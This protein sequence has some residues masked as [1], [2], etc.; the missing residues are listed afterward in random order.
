MLIYQQA[1]SLT[2]SAQHAV[3]L[4]MLPTTSKGN[5]PTEAAY[6]CEAAM[7]L[8]CPSPGHQTCCRPSVRALPAA[9]R[10]AAATPRDLPSQP[11]LPQHQ[12]QRIGNQPHAAARAAVLPARVT[13]RP[14]PDPDPA[15][16]STLNLFIPLSPGP[17]LKRALFQDRGWRAA[18]AGRRQ[19][20]AAVNN[21]VDAQ[22]PSE[23]Q[24]DTGCLAYMLAI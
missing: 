9:G 2:G 5:F 24:P 3:I 10:Q 22:G 17:C 14:Y 23:T 13:T 19:A 7:P 16:P 1:V 21:R 6:L 20:A 8:A 18:A 15:L 12:L 11:S 4:G